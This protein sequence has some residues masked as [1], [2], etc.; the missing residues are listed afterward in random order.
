MTASLRQAF[1]AALDES[2]R[3]AYLAH[4]GLDEQLAAMATTAVEAR[5]PLGVTP[6]ELVAHVARVA[7]AKTEPASLSTLRAGDLYLAYACASQAGRDRALVLFDGEYGRDIDLA[8]GRSGN[9]NLGKDEFRQLLRDKLFVPR[10]ERPPK[11]ADYA[12]RGDLRSWVRVTALRMIVDIVRQKNAGKEISVETEMLGAMPSP[13]EDPELDYIQRVYKS[14][15]KDALQLAF[16]SLT[17]RER[18]L[19]RHQVIHGLNIDQVG[20]IYRV[21]RT[22]AFRWI[23][24]AR[25]SLL[26]ETRSALMSRLRVGSGEFLSIMR[27]VQGDL[28]VS[29]RRLLISEIEAEPGSVAAPDEPAP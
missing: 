10:G 22:T 13:N 3:E 6:E 19:L 20:A 26:R 5:G 17:P 27:V 23:E 24:K 12:G 7:G 8:I 2:V 11:I 15:F 21:H 29:V 18:N 28:D 25:K 4:P 14:E 9:V 1:V 16:G